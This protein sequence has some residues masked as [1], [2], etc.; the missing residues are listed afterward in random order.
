M[1]LI[2]ISINNHPKYKLIVAANRDEFY[3]RKTAPLSEWED[4]PDVI[5]GRD[6]Q[7]KGTW[8]AMTKS[9]KIG[10]VTNYRDLKNLNPKAPTRGL[11][12]TDFLFNGYEAESYLKDVHLK[13][14]QYNGFSLVL[15]SIDE[16]YYYSNYQSRIIK[17][18]QGFYGL[19]NHLLDTPWPKVR[20]GKEKM[21]SVLLDSNPDPNA[22]FEV[23][24]DDKIAPDDQLPNTGLDIERERAVSA[25]FIKSP[26]YGSRCS[27]VVLVDKDNNVSYTER[28]YDLETFD[29]SERTFKWKV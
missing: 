15:G 6:L 2:F 10:M 8:M 13:A 22:I 25:M 23:L 20:R 1:C 9:G 26:N 29:H 16:L 17:L 24:T 28:V 19:S 12:V 5:G 18:T 21:A 27:T 14:P 7:A 3:A 11:L 4:H